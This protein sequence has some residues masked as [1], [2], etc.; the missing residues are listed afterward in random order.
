MY[1]GA[2]VSPV[3]REQVLVVG[4]S[5]QAIDLTARVLLDPEDRVLIEDPHYQGAR[6]IFLAHGARLVRGKVDIEGLDPN[7]FPAE[8]AESRLAY[9]TP[10]HQFPNRGNPPSGPAPRAP[11]LGTG[12]W[13]LH[14]GG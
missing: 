3:G 12:G 9:V 8:A 4:G 1:A 14:P 13:R 11:G 5:Q 7:S 10:S 6:Q 2:V